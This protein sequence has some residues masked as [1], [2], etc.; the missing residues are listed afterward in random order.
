MKD[1][2][3]KKKIDTL[4]Q[5]IRDSKLRKELG[6][7]DL[8]LMGIG[9]IVGVGIFV[10]TGV[11]ATIAGPGLTLSFVIASTACSFAALSYAE[12]S[13]AI[14]ISGSVYTYTYY[15]MGEF[16][17]WLIGWDLVL[18][19][20][21]GAA[22]VAAGWSGYFIALL[23]GIGINIPVELSAAYGSIPGTTT[24]F[25][26]PAFLIMMLVTYIISKGVKESARVN[27]LLV[28]VK[29]GIILLFIAIGSFYIRP[30][31]WQPFA[32][33]GAQGIF[34]AA[35]LIFFSYIGFDSISS[36]AEEVKNP[37][38]D[39]PR[40]ILFSLGFCTLLYIAV[41]MVMTGIV[42]F[43]KYIGTNNPVS[44]AIQSV[45]QEWF[46][47]MI[48][49][50]AIMGMTT[51]ILVLIYGQTRIFYAMSRDRLLP[52]VFAKLH[53]TY[54]SP[55]ASTWL[56]GIIG[57]VISS[58]LPLSNILQLTNLGT[59]VAFC[60]ISISVI[61]MRKTHP[62]LPRKFRCPWVPLLPLCAILSCGFLLSCLD[63]LVW[64]S[65]CVWL[66]IGLVIYF[67]Y[68]RHRSVLNE[69]NKV[70]PDLN[71]VA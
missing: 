36:A 60:L 21:L 3:R 24:W 27:N 14:P 59:L 15:T 51:V 49:I 23:A 61:V 47:E 22:A 71:R 1:I 25:N 66:I 50:A 43:E 67:S 13:S 68:S 26:L 29:I 9:A 8:T 40:G 45:G 16:F 10:V 2:F 52:P 56:V 17:A 33:F 42:P 32:P 5:D 62:D 65:F 20:T 35:A 4:L 44:F 19:Y 6:A 58:S 57:G 38:R 70:L 37:G 69:N 64:I 41:T 54:K 46:A 12:F 7:W 11:G 31:N 30:A 48:N 63:L 53:T 34:N 28:A 55:Y 18:E 39:L